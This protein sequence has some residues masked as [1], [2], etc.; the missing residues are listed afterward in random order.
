MS[1]NPDSVT[2]QG[3]FHDKVPPSKP[4]HVSGHRLGHQLGN[5]AAPEFHAKTF[6]P[7]TAPEEDSYQPNPIHE[8]PG[9]ALNPDV[10]PSSRTDPLDAYRG[11]TSQSIYNQAQYGRPMEGQTSRELHGM[12]PGKRKKEHSG[13]E[14]VGATDP[15][16]PTV[17]HKVRELVADKPEPIHRGIRGE[18][19]GAEYMQPETAERVATENKPKHR[20]D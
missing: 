9:Q 2:G 18:P 8:I 17:E 11:S 6:P 13:L 10:D 14:G 1:A 15:H 3:E 4:P 12:H 20:R 16:A 19:E 7:G 5:E